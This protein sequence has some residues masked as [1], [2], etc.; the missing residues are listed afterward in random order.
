MS[1]SQI[2]EPI[3]GMFVHIWM[4]FSWWFQIWSWNSTILTFFT[5]FVKFMTC[6]LHSPAAWKALRIFTWFHVGYISRDTKTTK[7]YKWAFY[8]LFIVYTEAEL[9][10]NHFKN[11]KRHIN[12]YV[13]LCHNWR[14]ILNLILVSIRNIHLLSFAYLSSILF[15]LTIFFFFKKLCNKVKYVKNLI[16]IYQMNTL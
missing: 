10:C 9:F 14:C 4:H 16:W 7:K 12:W 8:D 13:N 5:K 2:N 11:E 15:T 3:P 6:R 1:I